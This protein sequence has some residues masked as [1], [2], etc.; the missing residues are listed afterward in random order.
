MALRAVFNHL[1]LPPKVPGGPDANEAQVSY[2]VLARITDSCFTASSHAQPTWS[3]AFGAL[4]ASLD[5]CDV[6]H[7]SDGLDR[8]VLLEY[9]RRLEPDQMLVLHLQTQN[10]ALLFWAERNSNGKEDIIIEAFE[11]SPTT[12]AVLAAPRALEWSFPGRSCRLASADFHEPCF[13]QCLANFLE[14]ASME[15]LR[16]LKAQAIKADRLLAEDRDTSDPALVTEM[17]MSILEAVGEARQPPPLWKHVRDDVNLHDSNEPWRRLPFWLVLRVAARRQL[18]LVLGEAD[19]RF[20]YKCLMAVLFARLLKDSAG[21][22]PPDLVITLRGKLCRR[23]AKLEMDLKQVRPLSV[24]N[25]R[26]HF[27]SIRNLVQSAIEGATGQVEKAWEYFKRKTTLVTPRLPKHANEGALHLSLPNSGP[28]MDGLLV[29]QA[30]PRVA[31]PSLELPSPLDTAIQRAQDF[32]DKAFHLAAI[33]SC[34]EA[35]RMSH[36]SAE[37]Q[38]GHLA[39]L[40]DRL[41][42]STGALYDGDPVQQSCRALAVFYRWTQLDKAAIM[43]CPLLE[44]YAPAFKPEMLDAL[45]LPDMC[46]MHR[47]REMQTYLHSRHS[48][49][50]LGSIFQEVVDMESL[51][52]RYVSRSVAAQAHGAHV[53]AVSDSGKQ[54]KERE[55]ANLCR[56]YDMHT[57]GFS[58]GTCRCSYIDGQRDVR[59]CKRCWHGRIRKRLK[60]QVFEEHLPDREPARSTVLFEL[61]IPAHLAI[62]RD[63]TW[64]ILTT[65]T[66]PSRPGVCE[67]P[68]KMLSETPLW[69]HSSRRKQKLTLAS[70]IKCFIDTHYKFSSGKVAVEDVILPLGAKFELYDQDAEIWV[71]DLAETL[72]LQHLCG[73]N[74]PRALRSTVL[75]AVCHPP[76]RVDG[77]SSYEVQANKSECPPDLS[78]HEFAAHQELLSG[79]TRRWAQ[80]LVQLGSSSLNFS[81]EET[82]KLLSQL[83]VQAG[84]R[85]GDDVLRMVHVCFREPGFV[86]RLSE[87]V[88]KRIQSIL[89]NWREHHCMELLVALGLRIYQ[90]APDDTGRQRA[91]ALLQT[92]RSALIGWTVQLGEQVRT[93]TDAGAAQRA[94]GYCLWAGLLCRRTFDVY[95]NRAADQDYTLEPEQLALWIQASVALQESIRVDIDQLLPMEKHALMRDAKAAYRLAPLL[96]RSV[97]A[98]PTA[99]GRG[100]DASWSG[101]PAATGDAASVDHLISSWRILPSHDRWA[102]GCTVVREANRSGTA[103]GSWQAVHCNFIEG[104]LLVNGK[105]RGKLPSEIRNSEDVKAIFG[106]QNLLTYPS[107]MP[108]MTH[109]LATRVCDQEVHFGLD[110]RKNVIVQ[111]VSKHAHF[112]F[113]PRRI[114]TG[115]TGPNSAFDLPL[116]LVEGCTH[117]LNL[118]SGCLEI[119]RG[120]EVW[121][122]RPRDWTLDV[123]GRRA[124]RGNVVLVDPQSQV[125]GAINSILSCFERPDRLTVY[126][127]AT[128][129]LTV[130]IRRL[131]LSFRVN[132][133][134]RLQCCRLGA[135]ID[136]DQDAGTWYGLASKIVVRD[137]AT[138]ERSI[139]LPLGSPRWRRNGM[140]VEVRMLDSKEYGRFGID[141]VL[142][143]LTCAPEPRLLFVKALC[144]GLTSFC[145]PDPLTG[146]TGTEEAFAILASGTA[147]PWTPIN[148]S[149]EPLLESFS[150]LLPDREYYPRDLKRL[151]RVTWSEELTTTIQHDGYRALLRDII[152]KS[153]R[154]A[155]FAT[156]QTV[157]E[158]RLPRLAEHL[159]LRGELQRRLYERPS[160][161]TSRASDGNAGRDDFVPYASRDRSMTRRAAKVFEAAR[162]II[163]RCAGL[164]MSNRLVAMLESWNQSTLIGG[165]QPLSEGISADPGTSPLID[166]TEGPIQEKWGH[167]V[168]FCQAVDIERQQASV[169]FRLGLLA[170][171][172]VDMDV[173]HSLAAFACIDQLKQLKPP[174][175]DHFLEFRSRG[176][177]SPRE[178]QQL[179]ISACSAW[180]CS[181][182]RKGKLGMVDGAGRTEEEHNALCE[183]E[184]AQFCARLLAQWPAP[185][186]ELSTASLAEEVLDCDLALE[187]LA[188]DWERRRDNDALCDF[189]NHA[190]KVLDAHKGP[191]DA[192]RLANWT[193]EKNRNP[194]HHGVV[195]SS[196]R[197]LVLGKR[198]PVFPSTAPAPLVRQVHQNTTPTSHTKTT[199]RPVHWAAALFNFGQRAREALQ[200]ATGTPRAGTIELRQILDRFT[201][202]SDKLRQRYGNDLL[203]SLEALEAGVGQAPS[204]PGQQLKA[205]D[206]ADVDLR[207]EESRAVIAGYLGEI[208]AAL[209]ADDARSVWLRLGALWP[210]T[211]DVVFTLLR[212]SSCLHTN[213]CD[214]AM[215]KA[216][217]QYGLELTGLQRLRRIRRAIQR[218]NARALDDEL[219]NP[220]HQSWSP[221]E[222]ADW[223]LLEIDG[224]LLIRP[225]Q[226]DVAR[227]IIAPAS[228]QNSVLQ[229]NMGK[230]K[231]SVIVPMVVA[232][233]A[234]GEALARLI[235][236]KALL[237]A[238]AQITQARLGG[239]VGRTVRHIPFSRRTKTTSQMLDLYAR[240]HV[241]ARDTR[242][243]VLTSHEHILSFKLGGWQHLA[244]GKTDLAAQMFKFELWLERQSRDVLDECDFTLSVKTQLNYP[245]GSQTA[246]DGQPFRWQV[247]E[248]LLALVTDHVPTLR[249][250]HP[251]GVDV[252]E[253]PGS[254]PIVRFLRREAEEATV[255]LIIDSIC[256]GRCAYIR[257]TESALASPQGPHITSIRRL[258]TEEAFDH[259]VFAQAVSA[260][261]DQQTSRQR[262]LVIRGLLINKIL[263]TC[264]G[265]R[266]NVQYGLHPRRD[267]LAVPFEAK[268]TPSEH[269]EFGHPDVAILL[270]YLAFYYQGLTQQQLLQGLQHLLQSADPSQEYEAWTV[271]CHKLP[272]T[273]RRW[274]VISVE[275]SA[276]LEEL[277]AHLKHS[278]VVINYYL[279]NF[280]FPRHAKQFDVKLQASGWDIPL[281]PATNNIPGARTTGFS[282]TN[283]NRTM[284]PLTIRQDDLPSLRQ[285]SA[286]V[287][288]YL[289][290]PRNRAYHVT[291]D[292]LGKRLSETGLLYKLKVSG[293][294][295][296]IDAGAYILE[297]D[298]KA[299]A[300]EWLKIDIKARAAIYFGQD[301]RAW[302]HHRGEGKKDVPLLASQFADNL[303]ECLVYFDEAH[304]RGVD[305]KLPV[306]AR[307]AL[308]LALKQSKDFTMQ[309]AMRLRQLGTTQAVV[310]L[311]PPDVDQS[312]RDHL[313]VGN[314]NDLEIDSAHVISWL[315]EQTCCGHEDLQSL[316]VSQGVDFCRRTDAAWRYQRDSSS[317][318]GQ[319]REKVLAVIQRPE[320]Q[321]LEQLYGGAGSAQRSS[322]SSGVMN[323]RLRS[324]MSQLERC[325]VGSNGVAAD[326]NALQEVE[327][328][329]E[330][331][332]EVQVQVEQVRQVQKRIRHVPLVFPRLHPYIEQFVRT[333]FLPPH[334]LATC[335]EQAFSYVG[336]TQVGRRFG[337][338]DTGST[339]FVSAEF[340]RTVKFG[341]GAENTSVA[342]NF[343]RPVDWI[344]WSPFTRTALIVIPEEME[345]IIPILRL[346]AAAGTTNVHMV[347]YAAPT[348][349]AM[350]P[351]NSFQYYSFPQLPADHEFPPWFRFEVGIVAGRLYVGADEWDDVKNFVWPKESELIARSYDGVQAAGGGRL[352]ICADDPAAFLRAWLAVRHPTQDIQH[353]PM[354]YICMGRSLEQ[355]PFR[356]VDV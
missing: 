105:A 200:G 63:T 293:I 104:H 237:M 176:R 330:Q 13:Q 114:F 337:V 201:A 317:N 27:D 305:L 163:Q 111:S 319:Q 35:P 269:A 205:P 296:L 132:Q 342:D 247:A 343:L 53:Q 261:E 315:L 197:D 173:V 10:A 5:A 87:C 148:S 196:A 298:N 15:S 211:R 346:A 56:E 284:L 50:R 353:T 47:L 161:D 16:A 339:L 321:T 250:K 328:E 112:Q 14:Q 231:T 108:R 120:P 259:G 141:P 78:S 86:Q 312:I 34:Q 249:Q 138:R 124:Y 153:N 307:G 326:L 99:V 304:T 59:G 278:L 240:L 19:G 229:M 66:H 162:L 268:G 198:G 72:T 234:D 107:G 64:R 253:R 187:K 164:H 117:W 285:T 103:F 210:C 193:I 228:G 175:R 159:D 140:H 338:R 355:S 303:D 286:E 344:L 113:V 123:P 119:R 192:A 129:K 165:F 77:P 270:T 322:V 299:L 302:V 273:L 20:A 7:R 18:V 133:D 155:D 39:E 216:L 230:G 241:D 174:E 31:P 151:Q 158:L 277:W 167:L 177:P 264:L 226:V 2:D 281:V 55:W 127:P 4:E 336:R 349:K 348:T 244:D 122:K 60:I 144:H 274:D 30:P 36:L 289:L 79:I 21:A 80:I 179:T 208:D 128:G 345:L 139:L 126:Q 282:G 81:S 204:T 45:Q 95:A 12:T 42:S 252:L 146:R 291:V 134:G 93:T 6:L 314:G 97:V 191:R 69:Q 40:I 150:K 243:V 44:D 17:L 33:E 182:S 137:I 156:V 256:G 92:A 135:E 251:L 68:R 94:S 145:L 288:T 38:C 223:L 347:T 37:A 290:Q 266:W 46:D 233:L 54:A 160:L 221:N 203:Q 287:L 84:P 308:T 265:K 224:D 350:L 316:Y 83:A 88:E 306:H 341:R 41:F 206:I 248:A 166:Q 109:R 181:R 325:D 334:A 219:N 194:S 215:K 52:V 172:P 67:K 24:A 125:F 292:A 91:Q 143:R 32:T 101:R 190:Q 309:A 184:M 61:V 340:G 147:Q 115:E 199:A 217:V 313:S 238:T 28:H 76:P 74:V 85:L 49:A 98:H 152:E 169:V 276:Q 356:L 96:R 22:L 320:R 168:Q 324:I 245:G 154:L 90:L 331:E 58:T 195:P 130:D 1:V 3:A 89:T 239:L 262:L 232:A 202:T 207:I 212:S 279:D 149:L 225:D 275:D 25:C 26:A 118:D 214:S 51:A 254:F 311:A 227:A 73:V 100:V 323:P 220:G 333:G 9:F 62:Y 222:Y 23:M 354:G 188:T 82:T 213:R 295:I 186:W 43:A 301:D 351:F 272:E 65:L 257:P 297:M 352:G 209:A 218:D 157:K 70:P 171:G 185:A 310:F 116:E 8:A 106:N 267:P 329:V 142:G 11:A 121:Y 260:F 110:H 48:K 29:R 236:P 183:Q 258:F 335:F 189:A 235:V 131:D 294:R 300:K 246:V 332:R 180:T 280:V 75:P 71:K 318:P 271:G 57:S 178:L 327:Q 283:D 242:G 102:V 255:Q 170:F 263:I 136:P